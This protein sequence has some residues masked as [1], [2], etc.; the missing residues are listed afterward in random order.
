MKKLILK[1]DVVAR[2]NGNEMNQL[3]GGGYEATEE[4]TCDG[5]MTCQTCHQFTCP[6]HYSCEESCMGTCNKTC[7]TCP[8]TCVTTSM[9]SCEHNCS[10]TCPTGY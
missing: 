3:R 7:V 2:I 4:F 9:A 10:N 1:K 8:N 6:V 5:G